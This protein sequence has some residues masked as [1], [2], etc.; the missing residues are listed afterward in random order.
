MTGVRR[1]RSM[2]FRFFT[3]A[4]EISTQQIPTPLLTK[5]KGGGIYPKE[6]L[7]SDRFDLEFRSSSNS[8]QKRARRISLTS[9][10][11]KKS[12]LWSPKARHTGAIVQRGK[13]CFD[14]DS[15]FN[16]KSATLRRETQGSSWL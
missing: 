2:K 14:D 13:L 8:L 7:S 15:F 12:G 6:T 16:V 5:K 4:E 11:K 9:L 10:W 3:S 1:Y